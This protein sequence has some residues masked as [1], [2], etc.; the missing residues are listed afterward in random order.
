MLGAL[1]TGASGL[2]SHS[3]AMT[4]TGSNIAN[5]NTFGYKTHRAE[6]ADI[7]ATEFGT[8]NG[9]F[10]QGS[11]VQYVSRFHTQGNL[12]QTPQVTDLAIEGDGFF[13]LRDKDTDKLSYSREGAFEVRKDGVFTDRDGN[14]VMVKDINPI[15]RESTGFLKQIDVK[16]AKVA[17]SIT[18]DG[19]MKG[20]GITLRGNLNRSQ[21]AP[22][23][24]MNLDDVK[25]EMFNFATSTKIYDQAGGEHDAVI[26]FRRLPDIPPQLD[27]ATNL[28]IPGTTQRNVWAWFALSDGADIKDGVPGSLQAQGGGFLQFADD[29][30]FVGHYK[31]QI[32]ELPPDNPN[33]PDAGPGPK[34]L[35]RVASD[36]LSPRPQVGFDFASVIDPVVVGIDFGDGYDPNNPENKKSGLDG[37]TSFVAKNS[38]SQVLSDGNK[39]GT[40]ESVRI[41]TDGVI[42]GIFDSGYSRPIGKLQLAQFIGIQK[43]SEKGLNR[44]VE[45]NGSGD[46]IIGDPSVA[47]KGSIRSTFLEKSN[48]DLGREFVNMIE[49]QRGFQANTKVISTSDEMLSDLINVKR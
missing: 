29:G 23:V 34:I 13:V 45:T 39:A 27:P 43:L 7:M 5:V 21:P 32:S 9:N 11:L 8:T 36:G 26:A 12:E 24:P 37:M 22:T 17:A 3:Q 46:A 25:E 40:I 49:Y 38:F 41:D 35:V 20:T 48:V 42:E 14:P 30:R 19:T 2:R 44:Y 4:V 28:P 1:Q 33:D 10:G 18:G 15:T 31:G 16:N 47:G 6:F